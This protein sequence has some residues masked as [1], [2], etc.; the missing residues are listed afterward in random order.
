MRKQLG[1]IPRPLALLLVVV[2]IFGVAWALITPAWLSPDEDVHFS[3]SQTLGELGRLPGGAGGSVSSEQLKAAADTNVDP[4]VFFTYSQPEQS[5]AAYDAWLHSNQGRRDDGGGPNAASGYPPAYYLYETVPYVLASGGT[6]FDRLYLMRIFSVF[7][8]LVT[9][10]SAW[11]LAG[12]VFGRA[13]R[14]QLL[15]AATVGMWPM[16]T[17]MSA[18]V[19]PDSML[20]ATWGLAVWLGA[21]VVRRGLTVRNGLALGAA[22]GLAMV[23]KASS[24]ALI[25]AG[26]VA[27][28]IAIARAPHE[29][30]RRQLKGMAAAV[31]VFAVPVLAWY[32]TVRL[33]SRT[34]YAQAE[35]VTSGAG[36]TGGSGGPSIREFLSYVWQYYL[37]RVP[38]QQMHELS[39]PVISTYP[40]YNVWIG[41]GWAAFGWVTDFLPHPAYAVFLGI[42]IVVAA[43][44]AATG[45][46][47]LRRGARAALRRAWPLAL[48]FAA[49]FFPLWIGIHWSE[50]KIGSAFIQGRYLFPVAGLAGL[51]AAQATSL[52][53]QRFRGA[54]TGVVLG[55]LVVFQVASLLLFGSRMYA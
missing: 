39:I 46:R 9:A 22:I 11:L 15:T 27:I 36:G 45:V 40:A 2:A 52:L 43:A 8:L 49:A 31:G 29:Q 7:W 53:P 20:Y 38:G 32:V 26:L 28:G 17:F 23:T 16:L 12:E 37:P 6:I 41:T 47:A 51:V 35:L 54:A 25:P 1:K 3:Y 13:P 10:T 42:T 21:R 48:F 55:A 30:R 50:Y 14:R 34:A 18:S 5:R 44:A 19:N 4:T 33:N 24:I